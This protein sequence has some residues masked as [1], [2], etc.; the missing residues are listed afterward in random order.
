MLK[1][2]LNVYRWIFARRIMQKIN[3]IFLRLTLLGLGIN[4]GGNNWMSG[5]R[6]LIKKVLPGTIKNTP[7]VFFDIGANVG[8]YTK[9]LLDHFPDACIHAF[10][11]HPENYSHLAKR[12]FSNKIKKHNIAVGEASGELTLYDRADRDISLHASLYEG[13]I[14]E[15]HKKEVVKFKVAVESLDDFTKREGISYIDF[16]KIDTEGNEFD[17]LQGASKLLENGNIGCI[18]FEF[19]E[20][21]IISRVFFR[22]FRKILH[23]YELYRMLPKSLILLDDC[24]LTTEIFA[25]QNIVALP[26]SKSSTKNNLNL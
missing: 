19:N 13:V 7:P 21:N 18:H 14:S 3:V 26:K 12:T 22:D 5:E 6:Y 1:F 4:N 11:P 2:V 8:D 17:V 15:I 25:F 9:T 10:E 20:M 24:P 23:N 16:I